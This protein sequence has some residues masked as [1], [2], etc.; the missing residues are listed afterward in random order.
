M[1]LL[2]SIVLSYH[3]VFKPQIF[4]NFTVKTYLLHHTSQKIYEKSSTHVAYIVFLNYIF[5]TFLWSHNFLKGVVI[6]W[7]LS[8][9]TNF[10]QKDSFSILSTHSLV[11]L[12]WTITKYLLCNTPWKICKSYMTCLVFL[13]CAYVHSFHQLSIS[14]KTKGLIIVYCVY[15]ASQ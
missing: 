9:I 12:N 2:S 15:S 14:L 8:F 1:I 3:L 4:L 7:F 11:F 6:K 10:P 5:P 13:K